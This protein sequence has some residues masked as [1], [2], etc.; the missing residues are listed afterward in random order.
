MALLEVCFLVVLLVVGVASLIT[1]ATEQTWLFRSTRTRTATAWRCARQRFSLFLPEATLRSGTSISAFRA[2]GYLRQVCTRARVHHKPG[3]SRHQF[4]KLWT[5]NNDRNYNHFTPSL[6]LVTEVFS[7][8]PHTNSSS[9][10]P[11]SVHTS[12]RFLRFT[13]PIVVAMNISNGH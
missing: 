8:Q 11:S 3:T 13:T 7:H 9:L 5:I 2:R 4:A 1:T 10:E 6:I 12:L